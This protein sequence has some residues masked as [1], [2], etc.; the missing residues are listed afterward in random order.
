MIWVK[1]SHQANAPVPMEE[2][3]AG[4]ETSVRLGEPEKAHFSMATTGL[5]S[6]VLGTATT[7]SAQMYFLMV[8]VL[9]AIE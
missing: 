8:T 6:I 5:P 4:I 7:L 3:P 1:R 2:T 9:F